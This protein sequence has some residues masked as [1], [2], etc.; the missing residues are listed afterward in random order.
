MDELTQSLFQFQLEELEKAISETG[1]ISSRD[2]TGDD[3]ELAF[4]LQREEF[5]RTEAERADRELAYQLSG[6]AILNTDADDDSFINN[7]PNGRRDDDLSSVSCEAGESSAR[8]AQRQPQKSDSTQSSCIACLEMSETVEVPCG[9]HYCR[10]CTVQLFTDAVPDET[11]F[12]VRC[13]QKPIPTT[14]VGRYLG[15]N[16]T[17]QVEKKAIEYATTDRTYCHEPS[18]ATFITADKIHGSIGA[19]SQ[20]RCKRYTCTL[21]KQAA[22]KGECSKN[23]DFEQTLKLAE[24]NGWQRCEQCQNMV[25]LKDGCNHIT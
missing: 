15:S 22:H 18:C 10:E 23:Q 7:K 21:C 3:I 5:E 25:E 20:P 13:C 4:L 6:Q 8:A 14:L 1:G 24:A 9:H 12:P 17:S 19:C 16:L 11:L 2:D